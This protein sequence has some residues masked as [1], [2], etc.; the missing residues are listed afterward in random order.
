MVGDGLWHPDGRF[1]LV[2]Y[3]KVILYLDHL[4][5]ETGCLRLVPG[6]HRQDWPPE[7]IDTAARWGIRPHDVPC[8]APE[9]TPGDVILFNLHTVHNALNGGNRRRLLVMG[10]SAHCHTE[11]EIQDLKER[12]PETLY[13]DIMLETATPE[14]M[15]HL[16]QPLDLAERV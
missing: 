15:R 6:S 1:P 13:S 7:N 4:T 2:R 16:R 8:M 12:L 9:N 11:A 3:V 5:P 14:R 10:F